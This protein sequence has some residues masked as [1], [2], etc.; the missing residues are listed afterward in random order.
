MEEFPCNLFRIMDIPR[1][2]SELPPKLIA[3][4]HLARNRECASKHFIGILNVTAHNERFYP[5]RRDLAAAVV[6]H[7][8]ISPKNVNTDRWSFYGVKQIDILFGARY[9]F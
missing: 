1:R 8:R 6:I 9:Y 4:M 3:F 2:K 5:I 7:N